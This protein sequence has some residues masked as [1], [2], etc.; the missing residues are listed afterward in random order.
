MPTKL[1]KSTIATADPGEKEYFIWDFEIRNLGLRVAVSG[2][3]TFVYQY[4]FNKRPGRLT[5]GLAD[6]LSLPTA[7]E[8]AR[9]AAVQ[10][11]REID[12][13]AERDAKRNAITIKELAEKFDA[14][15][16]TFHVKASTAREYRRALKDYILPALGSKKVGDVTRTHIADLHLKMRD[17]P[18]HRTARRRR[19]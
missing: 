2:R 15:H 8:V 1:T 14:S 10:I 19:P 5:I 12:P 9:E 3:K 6:V 16:V 17:K 7:R 11:S 18:T 13:G 4:R